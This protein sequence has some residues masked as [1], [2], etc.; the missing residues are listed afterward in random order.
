MSYILN[1]LR[2]KKPRFRPVDKCVN[3]YEL[4]L[5][6]KKHRDYIAAQ[7]YNNYST[8]NYKSACDEDG[9]KFKESI[10]KS[11]I[12]RFAKLLNSSEVS[13]AQLEV[14]VGD[15]FRFCYNPMTGNMLPISAFANWLRG[16][17]PTI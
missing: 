12:E 5:I 4:E 15:V 1:F 6:F 17:H 3:Q 8:F 14:W 7:F 13:G 16:L 11:L 9:A 2:C 10:I